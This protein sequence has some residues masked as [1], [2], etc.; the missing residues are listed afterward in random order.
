MKAQTANH[1][2]TLLELILVIGIIA[3]LA[4]LLMPT[5]ASVRSDRQNL[6][7]AEQP[8]PGQGAAR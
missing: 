3:C 7:S 8:A 6:H 2:F 5:I 1:A 4:A